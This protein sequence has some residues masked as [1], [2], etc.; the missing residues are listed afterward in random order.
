VEGRC[1]G[2]LGRATVAGVGGCR[3]V[4]AAEAPVAAPGA[5]D[6]DPLIVCGDA[7][8]W[9][10]VASRLAAAPRAGPI[11]GEPLPHAGAA[12]TV[13]TAQHSACRAARRASRSIR[14]VGPC[15]ARK[16]T[17]EATQC[18]RMKSVFAGCTRRRARARTARGEDLLHVLRAVK[19][20]RKSHALSC[21][22]RRSGRLFAGEDLLHVLL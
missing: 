4:A 10:G 1:G 11:A 16:G 5:G 7:L 12:R 8:G 20:W 6:L 2:G 13:Q 9:R 22:P 15:K 14:S 3:G 21:G 18:G 19:S 17:G